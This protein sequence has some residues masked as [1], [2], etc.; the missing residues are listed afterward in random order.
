MRVVFKQIVFQGRG[1][2]GTMRCMGDSSGQVR[3]YVQNPTANAPL[4]PDGKLN[5]GGIVGS[6]VLS[7]VR[8]HPSWKEP[9]N[10]LV[11]I[12]TGEIAEDI[13]HYLAESEQTNSAIALGV[14][15]NREG[16]VSAAGGYLVQ[17]EA[18][19]HCNNTP[20]SFALLSQDLKRH[21]SPTL[22]G[23]RYFLM[24][25]RKRWLLLSGI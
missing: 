8:S 2:L 11:L 24:H 22:S 12:K 14:L 1:P 13:A 18:A 25:P 20:L 7:V 21:F 16:G 23:S 10:G 15:M 4:R 6:G 3:G 17:V 19:D 5:V 9:Y